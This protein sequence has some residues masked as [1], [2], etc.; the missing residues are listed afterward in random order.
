MG[1]TVGEPN[2]HK[3][4]IFRTCSE[5]PR[6]P[7]YL[8][9]KVYQICLQ[10]VKLPECCIDCPP[11]SSLKKKKKSRA[12]HLLPFWEFIGCSRVNVNFKITNKKNIFEISNKN[13]KNSSTVR[14]ST[15]STCVI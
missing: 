9:Y 8:L 4:Q 15:L 3:R 11:S 13:F 6:L 14:I 7:H 1:L 12:I 10:G 2:L 5:R